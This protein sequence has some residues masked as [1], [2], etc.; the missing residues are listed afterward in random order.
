M[1]F[2]VELALGLRKPLAKNTSVACQKLHQINATHHLLRHNKYD[3]WRHEVCCTCQ[4]HETRGG[5]QRSATWLLVVAS[6]RVDHSTQNHFT[7]TF[8]W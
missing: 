7:D 5:A 6:E 4:I 2:L 3:A 8:L 1:G